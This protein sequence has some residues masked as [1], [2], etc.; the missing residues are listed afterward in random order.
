MGGWLGSH[1]TKSWGTGSQLF[2]V[3]LEPTNRAE[4]YPR[5]MSNADKVAIV[6]GAAR[7]IGRAT[8]R[9]LAEA[10]YRVAM[11][12]VQA[13]ELEMAALALEA[14][15]PAVQR[16]V[17]SVTDERAVAEAFE[18]VVRI[19]RRLDVLVNCAGIGHTASV[20][21]TPLSRWKEIL[22]VNLTG[23]FVTC[24]TAIP[25]ML[26]GGSGIIIN[27]V[28]IA[29]KTAFAGQGAYCASKWG[30]LGFTRVLAAEVRTQGIRVTAV[31]PGAVDTRFWDAVD[32]PLDRR[33]MLS[34]D[35]V[36]DAIQFVVSQPAEVSTDELEILPAVGI[37]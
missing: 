26:A 36:A 19:E 21:E 32:L 7:G 29:G 5:E 31:C 9:R 2:R 35:H 24:R 8:A 28:S 16:L 18:R 33:K 20:Q 10:R 37:L 3:W 34:P 23:M 27:V 12:D 1:A 15:G 4:V 13:D 11:L 6:T 25:W 14:G 17:C 30:A 22:D